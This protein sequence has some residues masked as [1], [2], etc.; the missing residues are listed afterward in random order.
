MTLKRAEDIARSA[1]RDQTEKI[2]GAPYITHVERVVAA[3]DGDDAKM[4]AWLH[5]VLEDSPLTAA[6]LR[7]AGLPDPVV[8]AVVM[9]TRKDES[10][11]DYIAGL[12]ARGSPLALTVKLADLRDHL[13][14]QSVPLPSSMR[15]RYDKALHALL[16]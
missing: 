5:D 9:L 12:R 15:R 14:A 3:V 2:G 10:Y 4:V 11:A 7:A 8:D 1:H 13:R 6:D 16:R